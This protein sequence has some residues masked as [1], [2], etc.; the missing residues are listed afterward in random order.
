MNLKSLYLLSALLL[1]HSAFAQ[2]SEKEKQDAPLSATLLD[3]S[4]LGTAQTINHDN[5]P[6]FKDIEIIYPDTLSVKDAQRKIYYIVREI[7]YKTPVKS[8]NKYYGIMKKG[9]SY[10][11]SGEE[12][13]CG[14]YRYRQTIAEASFNG[15]NQALGLHDPFLGS[16]FSPEEEK[17][18]HD[19]WQEDPVIPVVCALA[20]KKK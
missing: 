8:D 14:K 4:K 5:D 16:P 10:I 19:L 13:F 20:K 7:R 1:T 18:A 3:S 15:K 6:D 12:I 2:V 11:R 9:T 17:V